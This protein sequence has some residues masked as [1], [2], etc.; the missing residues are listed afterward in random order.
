MA[1]SRSRVIDEAIEPRLQFLYSRWGQLGLGGSSESNESSA[2]D[3][4]AI[5][6]LSLEIGRW[7][8]RFFDAVLDW[9]VLNERWINVSR[10]RSLNDAG[11]ICA[12]TL[13][14]AVAGILESLSTSAKWKT[15]AKSLRP[16]STAEPAAVFR[17]TGGRFQ[18][19]EIPDDAWLKYGW[20]RPAFEAR[21]LARPVLERH[22]RETGFSAE[23]FFRMRALFGINIRADA[24]CFLAL[25]RQGA[26]ASAVA[27]A[28]GYS[29][30]RTQD[31]L[32]ELVESGF[33]QVDSVGGKRG[34]VRRFWLPPDKS[35]VLG[36]ADSAEWFDWREYVAGVAAEIRLR[37]EL[38]DRNASERIIEAEL[39]KVRER[40]PV[41]VRAK[42]QPVEAGASPRA[43]WKLVQANGAAEEGE[44]A[45]S[46]EAF[47]DRDCLILFGPS[48]MGKTT[49]LEAYRDRL[50]ARHERVRFVEGHRI[51]SREELHD[52]L[53]GDLAANATARGERIHVILDGFDDARS[54]DPNFGNWLVNELED[55]L[56]TTAEL[57][58][59]VSSRESEW[60]PHVEKKLRK[61]FGERTDALRIQPLTRSEISGIAGAHGLN[62]TA[63]LEAVLK[64]NVEALA[65][66]PLTHRFLREHFRERQDFPSTRGDLFEQAIR[67]L[68]TYH[69]EDRSKE[70][71]P[72]PDQSMSIARRIAALTLFTNRSV[73]TYDSEGDAELLR[74][75]TVA[76]ADIDQEGKLEPDAIQRVLWSPLFEEN[77][78][79]RFRFLHRSLAE[80][81]AGSW[82]A[83]A[84]L[85]VEQKL[86]L[87]TADEG[88]VLA[89]VPQLT[90]T[91]AWAGAK[92]S[93]LF[94]KLMDVDPQALLLADASL[95]SPSAQAALVSKLLDLASQ[96]HARI[97]P[98][99]L[100]SAGLAGLKHPTLAKQLQRWLAESSS[101][102]GARYLAAR[103]AAETRCTELVPDLLEIANASEEDCSLRVLAVRAVGEVG[104]RTA[105]SALR[106]LREGSESEDPE[107]RVLG[108]V[109][110]VCWPELLSADELL[111]SLRPPDSSKINAYSL[112]L[113]RDIV[114]DFSEDALEPALRWVQEAPPFRE[115]RKLKAAIL[116]WAQGF[117]NNATRVHLY[118]ETL[119]RL[120]KE[121]SLDAMSDPLDL[122]SEA[123]WLRELLRDRSLWRRVIADLV[124]EVKTDEN[125]KELLVYSNLLHQSSDQFEWMIGMS[126]AAP[127]SQARLLWASLASRSFEQ[128]NGTHTDVLLLAASTNTAV[129]QVFGGVLKPV[130]LDSELAGRLRRYWESDLR[131]RMLDGRQTERQ[132]KKRENF[133]RLLGAMRQG[134]ASL[135]W[136]LPVELTALASGEEELNLDLTKLD[137][138]NELSATEQSQVVDGAAAFLTNT[139]PREERWFGEPNIY[140]RIAAAG[141]KALVLLRQMR[142]DDFRQ[143]PDYVWRTWMPT[144]VGFDRTDPLAQIVTEARKAEPDV[145]AVWLRRTLE[146]N[147]RLDLWFHLASWFPDRVSTD[148]AQA[149]IELVQGGSVNQRFREKSINFLMERGFAPAFEYALQWLRNVSADRDADSAILPA[150]LLMTHATDG[151]AE[152]IW[153]AMMLSE[154]FAKHLWQNVAYEV[155]VEAGRAVDKWP[156]QAVRRLFVWLLERFPREKDPKVE[157]S[158]TVSSREALGDFRDGLIPLLANRATA[159]SARELREILRRYPQ[160]HWIERVLSRGEHRRRER[161]WCPPSVPELTALVENETRRLVRTDR[162]LQLLVLEALERYQ[163]GFPQFVAALW[164]DPMT[165]CARPKREWELSDHMRRELERD[166][167]RYGVGVDCE[168]ENV[169]GQKI[170]VKVSAS[171]SGRPSAEVIIEVKGVWNKNLFDDMEN[172]LVNRYLR[173]GL[174]T[175]GVY[176]VFWFPV[177]LSGKRVS[178]N[179]SLEKL[180]AKLG[181][182]ANAMK[183]APDCWLET[184]VIDCTA[185]SARHEKPG[186]A[187]QDVEP[188]RKRKQTSRP[189]HWP[190]LG[191]F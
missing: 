75:E 96:K 173:S 148:V 45:A 171:S 36:I 15:L 81:L 147:S 18:E 187:N 143:L 63:F 175:C 47:E 71:R 28:L 61:H 26:H 83:R 182:T 44:F 104:D 125:S 126:S 121:R 123:P 53:F 64:A 31:T 60:S 21:R 27:R 170:D 153:S 157:G 105:K 154:S 156:D 50:R 46:L 90:E 99:D 59:L 52:K 38:Q 2:I 5:L 169:H 183:L 77:E 86:D 82:L 42:R 97:N 102:R 177:N 9:L 145:F 91:M 184:V 163:Q 116:L 103:I 39:R 13:V 24:I 106:R 181:E 135:W 127:E 70:T 94:E 30:R 74:I 130:E 1:T 73:V 115:F 168:V 62:G 189:V 3:P 155:H 180:R 98:F 114:T 139:S 172:Q 129:Q 133:S 54:N 29:Q 17:A 51:T 159:S 10:L 78:M 160:E 151:G 69:R 89:L 72:F 84:P 95:A 150:R 37:E 65:A 118:A 14:G 190:W 49:E 16:G 119:F 11:R 111:T 66:R 43:C 20:L 112:F 34:R 128:G 136:R 113:S 167:S 158:H 122:R 92:E 132:V 35:E 76:R 141:L 8:S 161:T 88:G 165:D 179:R 58:L 144:I 55:T 33:L 23:T 19:D 188:V 152:A 131:S 140:D 185:P 101:A 57:R 4:E 138:W 25:N 22:V 85:S 120:L 7:D 124:E 68:C 186:R 110:E 67:T 100:P 12:P 162:E 93:T 40:T 109:L 166:L 149:L 117:L 87:G 176:L 32:D 41:P 146:R 142:P 6:L 79:G 164:N 174:S 178:R 134:N 56:P 191:E 137:S 80:Y 107:N 48:G 108:A